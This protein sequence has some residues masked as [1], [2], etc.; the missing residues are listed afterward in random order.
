MKTKTRRHSPPLALASDFELLPFGTRV[1]FTHR[2]GVARYKKLYEDGY[3]DDPSSIKGLTKNSIFGNSEEFRAPLGWKIIDGLYPREEYG[4]MLHTELARERFAKYPRA[5]FGAGQI[6]NKTVMV[7]PEDSFGW[8]IGKVRKAIG[9]S[10]PGYYSA[11]FGGF[12]S[13]YDPGYLVVDMYVDLY[14]V[15]QMYDGT[16]Y[17]YCPMWAVNKV[18]DET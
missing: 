10:S 17:V 3:K 8:I 12:E 16:Q 13:D 6:T 18:A 15:K 7:W 2:A 1:H 14:V 5:K 9:A 4:E 11:G